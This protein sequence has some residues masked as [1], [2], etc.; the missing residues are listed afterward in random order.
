ML[1]S[2]LQGWGRGL[3]TRGGEREA[4]EK[5]EPRNELLLSFLNTGRR[6]RASARAQSFRLGELRPG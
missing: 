6:A 4:D 1:G 3:D 5:N 2:L